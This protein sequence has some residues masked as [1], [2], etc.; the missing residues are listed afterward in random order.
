MSAYR[1][2]NAR[3]HLPRSVR[4]GAATTP[5]ERPIP[6][7]APKRD[8]RSAGCWFARAVTSLSGPCTTPRK[9]MF[10]STVV[11]PTRRARGPS[12]CTRT[13]RSGARSD[14]EDFFSH[15]TAVLR[16]IALAR[17][18][19]ADAEQAVENELVRLAD[20]LRVLGQQIERSQD[21]YARSVFRPGELAVKVTALCSWRQWLTRASSRPYAATDAA[22]YHLTPQ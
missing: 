16:A 13:W 1:P 4:A 18:V 22:R 8:Y 2:R 11:R 9:A 19:A 15:P 10:V 3:D 20:D 6:Q 21:E 12:A 14:V 17:T 5:R 7:G